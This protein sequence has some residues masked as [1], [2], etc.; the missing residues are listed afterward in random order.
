M[1]L[2]SNAVQCIGPLFYELNHWIAPNGDFF[3]LSANGNIRKLKP[4]NNGRFYNWKNAGQLGADGKTSPMPSINDVFKRTKNGGLVS[5]HALVCYYFVEKITMPIKVFAESIDDTKPISVSNVHWTNGGESSVK[6]KATKAASAKA[7]P[8]KAASAKAPPPTKASFGFGGSA[9]APPTKASFG[10]G[11]SAK[12]APTK[13]SFGFGTPAKAF[14]DLSTPEQ[15]DKATS[16]W[17]KKKK[18]REAIIGVRRFIDSPEIRDIINNIN[19]K[20][21]SVHKAYKSLLRIFHPDILI[22]RKDLTDLDRFKYTTIA[23]ILTNAKSN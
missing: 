1:P 14:A 23:K 5:I 22:R 20:D 13:A 4:T 9:K 11:R 10:F 2:P 17:F 16:S 19:R 3:I 7:T 6:S 8:P 12:A 15:F 21:E 18:L